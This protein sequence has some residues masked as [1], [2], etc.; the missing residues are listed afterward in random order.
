MHF[1][2]RL[3]LYCFDVKDSLAPSS[4]KPE[5]LVILGIA[6]KARLLE[7]AHTRKDA[8]SA[9]CQYETLATMLIREGMTRLD[10]GGRIDDAYPTSTPPK[11]CH[12]PPVNRDVF[13]SLPTKKQIGILY[14]NARG[15]LWK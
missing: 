12:A 10:T 5:Y 14:V 15:T 4:A 2:Y 11:A 9:I 6:C 1:R 13:V 7:F 3:A 8:P